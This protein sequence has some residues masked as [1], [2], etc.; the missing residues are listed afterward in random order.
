MVEHGTKNSFKCTALISTLQYLL[1]NPKLCFPLPFRSGRL[2]PA[3]A[4]RRGHE[5]HRQLRAPHS[6]VRFFPWFE[7]PGL[8]EI[9]PHC[10]GENGPPGQAG[11]GLTEVRVLN[12]IFERLESGFSKDRRVQ[13]FRTE[14]PEESILSV[15]AKNI[16][17]Q[18]SPNVCGETRVGS[19]VRQSLAG[20]PD[21]HGWIVPLRC[22]WRGWLV[23]KQL[24]TLSRSFQRE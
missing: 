20:T 22:L 2:H 16:C 15:K 18:G 9:R 12:H 6:G 8:A 10:G 5:Q 1:L 24:P 4:T 13:N 19:A 23:C 14:F 11:Q 21:K 17:F 7:P 3:P